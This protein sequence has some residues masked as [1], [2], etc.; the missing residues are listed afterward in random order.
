MMSSNDF[1]GGN[2]IYCHG[3][4]DGEERPE[5]GREGRGEGGMGRQT[6]HQHFIQEHLSHEGREGGRERPK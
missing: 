1:P 5:G 6:P 4:R 2:L 3:G